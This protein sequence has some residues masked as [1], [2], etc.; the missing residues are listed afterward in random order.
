MGRSI[1]TQPDLISRAKEIS[2]DSER[3]EVPV[4]APSPNF[5]VRLFKGDISLPV[6]Y[7]V[8][9][10]LIGGVGFWI[11]LEVIELNYAT[12]A[13]SS[14]GIWLTQGFYWFIIACSLYILIAIWRSAG[15]YS[16]KAVWAILARVAVVLGALS[17]AGNFIVGM[18]QGTNSDTTL[19]EEL[20]IMNKSLPVMMDDATRLD[21]I[22]LQGRDIYYNYTLINL[23]EK[24]LD[25]ERFDAVMTPKIKT[26][27][28]ENG[29]TR[30]LLDEGR[31]L[32]YM[33]RDK[34][35]N[36]VSKIIVSRS[37]CL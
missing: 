2:M 35:S 21:H 20:R 3:N 26:N 32:V 10:V 31:N 8:F 36:P 12:I 34:Q 33:Y 22:S 7:W 24:D 15:K 13:T 6:T 25:I 28:C 1:F 18:R 30:P 16:G 19:Q 14:S 17:L 37:D 11:V 29:A 9:G 23:L 5:F 27:G 4:V